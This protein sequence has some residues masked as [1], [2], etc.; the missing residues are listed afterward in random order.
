MKEKIKVNTENRDI[1]NSNIKTIYE[2]TKKIND[3]FNKK[4]DEVRKIN[5]KESENLLT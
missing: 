2:E 4:L 5:N 1:N 3:N